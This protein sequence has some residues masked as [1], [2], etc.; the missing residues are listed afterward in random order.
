MSF[1][2][3]ARTSRSR[4]RGF[5][6]QRGRS[7]LSAQTQ[8]QHNNNNNEHLLPPSL[9]PFFILCSRA[10]TRVTSGPGRVESGWSEPWIQKLLERAPSSIYTMLCSGTIQ[11]ECRTQQITKETVSSPE[12]LAMSSLGCILQ[13]EGGGG[14]SFFSIYFY[15]HRRRRRRRRRDRVVHRM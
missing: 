14:K 11:Y 15:T 10:T 8:P 5:S 12:R 2:E 13:E 9:P 4:F 1:F 7:Q 6:A 3:R